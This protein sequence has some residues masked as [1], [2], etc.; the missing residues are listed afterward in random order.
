MVLTDTVLWGKEAAVN[1]TF[2]AIVHCGDHIGKALMARDIS[3]HLLAGILGIL[4]PFSVLEVIC[5]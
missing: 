3:I 2:L 4:L 1:C 5:Q